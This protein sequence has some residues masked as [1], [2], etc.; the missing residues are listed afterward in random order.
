MTDGNWEAEAPPVQKG[1][2][3]W[4][5]ISLGC[6]G[7]CALLFIILMATCVGGGLWVSKHGLPGVMDKA[8]GSAFLD[9]TWADMDRAVT[10]LR[11]EQGTRALYL[12]NPGLA[13]DYATVEDFLKEAEQW[14][15]K[16]GEFPRQRPTLGELM[17]DKKGSGHFSVSTENSRTR[18]DYQIPHGGRLYLVME[19]GKVVDVRVE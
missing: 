4:A 12:A 2:P 3:T 6:C 16:L 8:V 17:R 18:V 5:K 7:G 10:S 11:T 9:K 1:M 14:R 13:E 15:P 19:A